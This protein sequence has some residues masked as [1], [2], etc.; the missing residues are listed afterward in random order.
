MG[1][2]QTRPTQNDQFLT[3]SIGTVEA[4]PMEMAT[5]MAT[6]AN[7]GVHHKPYVVAKVVGPDGKVL[8]DESGNAGDEVLTKDVADCEAN[9]LRGVVTGGTGTNAAFSGQEVFGKTGTT[10]NRADAWF[11]G[12]NPA[13]SGQQLATA[14]WF[15]NR[16]GQI[17]GA[18]FGGDS[19]APVFRAFMS[20]ALANQP[21]N[22]LP[23]P[24]PVCARP[25]QFVNP[26]GGRG[27]QVPVDLTQLPTVSQ[28]PGVRTQ[29]TT[30]L[31]RP[32]VTRP[33]VTT[34]IAPSP[35]TTTLK[36]PGG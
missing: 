13:G 4:T 15:G 31:T 3:L 9:V 22:P 34:T 6:I 2:Q 36:Q 7:G 1:V 14:V 32:P 11:I 26:D 17:A 35:T 5:V 19:S 25:G 12:A 8:I 21:D 27:A 28:T 30:P 33:P 18:G 23:D 16:T 20:Q 29:N 24:G 10:D